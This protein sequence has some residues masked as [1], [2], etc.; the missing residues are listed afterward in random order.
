MRIMI[1]INEIRGR[2]PSVVERTLIRPLML[3]RKVRLTYQEGFGTVVPGYL[4]ETEYLGLTDRFAT[5]GWGF[6]AGLQPNINQ[7]DYYTENDW[8]FQNWDWISGDQLLNQQVTQNYSSDIQGQLTIEPFNDFRIEVEAK[9][10]YS[11]F[12]SE[13][14]RRDEILGDPN[15]RFQEEFEH[16]IPRDVGSYTISY[17]SMN[18]LFESDIVGLFNKFEDNRVIAADILCPDCPLHDDPFQGDTL[19]FPQGYGRVQQ[20]VLLPAFI[21][22]YTGQEITESDVD[23]DYTNILFNELPR[24]NWK[25]TYNGLSKIEAFKEIFAQFNLSHGY[26]S[27]LTVNS[28][29]S[30]L[31]FNPDDPTVQ[32]PETQDYYSRFEI[33]D[34]VIQEQFSPLIG[35]DVRT[36]NGMSI[37]LD[38]KKSRNLQMSFIDNGL[39]ETQTS[40]YVAGFGYRV[41]NFSLPFLENKRKRGRGNKDDE[42]ADQGQG[43]RGG[44]RGGGLGQRG[45]KDLDITFDFSLRDDVTF[46]HLLDQNVFEPTR[47]TRAITISP[48]AEYQ[49]NKQLSLRFFFDFRRTIPKV[50][51]S[52]PITNTRGGITVR[53][54]LTP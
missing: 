48:A 41:K 3:M 26:R 45:I 15:E 28:F 9:R 43:N 38:F 39:N 18:T 2:E 42:E 21:A 22:A 40:E 29:Q 16:L 54:Q 30:D 44:N 5:P 50:S 53:F 46:R 31:L 14:F 11:E 51:Q 6:V 49:L 20:S 35:L 52:F 13:F 7:A 37:R 34:I 8:L 36:K 33:P 4:P 24:P 27:T 1:V 17:F 23:V 32:N 47:G 12:H 10:S 19:G 25:L